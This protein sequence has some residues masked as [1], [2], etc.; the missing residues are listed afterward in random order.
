MQFPK[1]ALRHLKNRERKG[2]SQRVLQ[3]SD[4][5]ERSSY[6]PNFEDGSEEETEWQEGCAREAAWRLDKSILKLKEKNKAV[7]LSPSENWCLPAPSNLK[8]EEREFVVD[9]G[10]SMHMISKK[11]LNSAEL[12]TVTTS[13]SPTTVITANGE[14]QTHE[15]ATVYVKGLDI[16]LT[17][18][19]L[20]NTPA[21]LSLG[22]LCD[23]HEYSYEWINGQ[24]PHLIENGIRMP[25]NTENF[26][27]IV[28]PGLSTSSSSSLPSLRR[29]DA[30]RNGKNYFPKLKEKDKDTF[31]SPSDVW[32]LPAPSSTRL[33]ERKF[34][35]DSEASMQLLSR[36][37]L[38]SAELETVRVSRNP[39]TVLTTNG[40]VQ[41]NEEAAVY[42]YDFDVF[43][44]LQIV[45]ARSTVPSLR[46]L[47][48]DHGYSCEWTSGQKP[49]LIEN[50]KKIQCNTDNYVPGVV[51][52]LSTE[53][54]GSSTSTSSTSISQS[55]RDAT[56]TQNKKSK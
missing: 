32:C 44:T 42:V 38:N 3:H 40:E 51:P 34:V 14:V 15:E 12:E 53:P 31:F 33:E 22:K 43:L 48:E 24:K 26:V 8:P 39:T 37:D 20:E 11:D 52:G 49:Q 2:P 35:V 55:V 16:F 54:S 1:G 13:R 27:P 23:E 10:A 7:F 19:V 5:H 41:T 17:M 29:R 47:C 18:K 30:G 6:A 21:V 56:E 50:G 9:S 46:K 25:C 4:P 45:E 36:K 28:V